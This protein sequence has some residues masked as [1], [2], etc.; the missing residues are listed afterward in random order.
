MLC[1]I[2]QKRV[3][4]K[5]GNLFKALDPLHDNTANGGWL[6]NKTRSLT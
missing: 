3:F 4:G 1:G 2:K 6:S 5:Y